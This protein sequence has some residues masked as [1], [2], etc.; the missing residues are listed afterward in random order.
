M[1]IAGN[2]RDSMLSGGPNTAENLHD[3]GTTNAARALGHMEASRNL[4]QFQV[5]WS[6]LAQHGLLL[7][8]N[9]S[10]AGTAEVALPWLLKA[11]AESLQQQQ[12]QQQHWL[13]AGTGKAPPVWIYSSADIG[14]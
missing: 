11:T 1:D 5:M 9:N 10:G 6:H 14:K 2:G 3:W 12:Q 7:T 8:T 4:P 13:A